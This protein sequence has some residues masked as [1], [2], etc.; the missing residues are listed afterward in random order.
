MITMKI[1]YEDK[2]TLERHDLIFKYASD[3]KHAMK[4]AKKLRPKFHRIVSVTLFQL[5]T[6]PSQEIDESI[7]ED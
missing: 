1:T 6:P 7:F 3:E 2:K 5:T 4:I